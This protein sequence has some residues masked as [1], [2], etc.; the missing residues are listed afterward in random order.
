[1]HWQPSTIYTHPRP[2][3]K[4]DHRLVQV[5]GISAFFQ[6]AKKGGSALDGIGAGGGMGFGGGGG[7][8]ASNR[9]KIDFEQAK[10]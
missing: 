1:L 8:V 7:G 4:S 6:E 2:F 10:K 9:S 3:P 5:F